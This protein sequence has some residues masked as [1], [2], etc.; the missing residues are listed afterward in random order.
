[1]SFLMN[2]D[3]QTVGRVLLFASVILGVQAYRTTQE[4]VVAST[5]TCTQTATE[6]LRG[7][8]RWNYS[9]KCPQQPGFLG[10]PVTANNRHCW[11][12]ADMSEQMRCVRHAEIYAGQPNFRDY[13]SS[14]LDRFLKKE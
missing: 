12:I 13:N 14:I 2:R 3:V 8:I 7:F 11:G 6:T 5:P 10:R 4:V 1:M 9:P